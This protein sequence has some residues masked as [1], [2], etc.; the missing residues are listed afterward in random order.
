MC[1]WFSHCFE[2]L[3]LVWGQGFYLMLR[4]ERLYIQG[5]IWGQMPFIQCC[6]EYK[7]LQSW[8]A[9][10]FIR[11]IFTRLNRRIGSLSSVYVLNSYK[12]GY[13]YRCHYPCKFTLYIVLSKNIYKVS[14]R[15]KGFGF[16]S[17][18]M[19]MY[20]VDN[21]HTQNYWVGIL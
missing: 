1:M 10:T 14:Y 18:H 11:W 7:Y 2:Y 16:I 12:V 8:I 17:M 19:Y 5:W 3:G 6:F 21:L 15:Y 4:W 9:G 20:K 13:G